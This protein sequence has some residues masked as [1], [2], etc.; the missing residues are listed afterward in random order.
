MKRFKDSL[1]EKIGPIALGDSNLEDTAS[2][3]NLLPNKEK[4]GKNQG[5]GC[6]Q[7]SRDSPTGLSRLE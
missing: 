2:E 7:G 6:G 3:G 5:Q 4:L 1:E